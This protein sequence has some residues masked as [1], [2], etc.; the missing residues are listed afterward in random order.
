MIQAGLGVL[1]G[2]VIG[3]RNADPERWLPALKASLGAWGSEPHDWEIFRGDS[4]TCAVPADTF[5]A[6]AAIL[7][8]YPALA[9]SR[10]MM[11]ARS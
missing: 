4:F 2:D 11:L 6:A 7:S 3:S 10:A 1:T 8:I 9:A 5:A